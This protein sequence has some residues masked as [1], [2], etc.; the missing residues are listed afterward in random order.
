MARISFCLFM[1]A[2][3]VATAPTPATKHQQN[4]FQLAGSSFSLS[5]PIER[6]FVDV[7]NVA[8]TAPQVSLV[9]QTTS[10]VAHPL[11]N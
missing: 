2:Q 5:G 8:A 3:L 4:A 1:G 10:P 6:L 7:F 11:E 9:H